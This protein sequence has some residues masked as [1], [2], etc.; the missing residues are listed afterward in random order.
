MP[1][2]SAAMI[3]NGDGDKQ[4]HTVKTPEVKSHAR[5]HEL[6]L[7]YALARRALARA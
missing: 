1:L 6:D 7:P 4:H 3:K 2:K 5:F